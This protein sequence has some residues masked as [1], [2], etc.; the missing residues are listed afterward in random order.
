M[1]LQRLAVA[2][3]GTIWLWKAYLRRKYQAT[4]D[5]QTVQSALHQIILCKDFGLPLQGQRVME[6]GSGWKPVIPLI[7][8]MAGA[9]PILMTDV[10]RT[11]DLAMIHTA[12]AQVRAKAEAVRN[13][14]QDLGLSLSAL[15]TGPFPTMDA[16]L[17]ALH[18]EYWIGAIPAEPVQ[19]IV[20]HNVLEHIPESLLPT[21]FHSWYSALQPGGW[22]IHFIDH[23]DH[24]QHTN[25]HLSPL[26][27]LRFK[28]STWRFWSQGPFHQ[29]RLRWQE[30]RPLF[31]TA[32]FQILAWQKEAYAGTIETVQTL[33]L[34]TRYRAMAPE[35]LAVLK[36]RVVLKKP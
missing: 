10:S 19:G 27:F 25:Q 20:S 6:I 15:Q 13:Q 22:M 9:D 2:L 8:R 35:D 3:P 36:S 12:L 23:S 1:G 32:G 18:L 4:L 16:A 26:H 33:P 24:L 29:N 31:E 11:M 5:E 14:L 7:L 34:S 17:E 30:Y 21:L 28:D